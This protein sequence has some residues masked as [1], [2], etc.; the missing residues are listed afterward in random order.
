VR[1]VTNKGASTLWS[2]NTKVAKQ[3]L[4]SLSGG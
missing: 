4:R 1:H 3:I 2:M